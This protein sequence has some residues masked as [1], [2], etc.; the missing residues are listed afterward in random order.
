MGRWKW[1][2]WKGLWKDD[3]GGFYAKMGCFVMEILE[4]S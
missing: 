2:W 3:L 1:W 4:V